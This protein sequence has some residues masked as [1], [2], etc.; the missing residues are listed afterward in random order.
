MGESEQESE[1]GREMG[2]SASANSCPR[3]S[4]TP[5]RVAMVTVFSRLETQ[6]VV[7]KATVGTVTSAT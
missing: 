3:N 6:G 1:R 2:S 7:A 5:E 4:R